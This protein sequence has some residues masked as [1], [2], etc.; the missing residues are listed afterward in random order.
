M[1]RRPTMRRAFVAALASA[2]LLAPA[3]LAVAQRG[4]DRPPP[5]LRLR[6]ARGDL[7]GQAAHQV[8]R[9][10][11]EQPR[12]T[13]AG[14]PSGALRVQ[15]QPKRVQLGRL[16]RALPA[17]HPVLAWACR[18]M[19]TGRPLGV[20]R[21]SERHRLDPDGPCVRLL[22]RLE[23]VRLSPSR[24]GRGRDRTIPAPAQRPVPLRPNRPSATL[25]ALPF[26]RA[27][28]PD[29]RDLPARRGERRPDPGPGRHLDATLVR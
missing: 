28:R 9:C 12:N 2:S 15:P 1:I 18:P 17:C 6:L 23:G 13:E 19:G 11:L 16:R 5:C 20:Q 29:R 4:A 27:R 25:L 14:D 22:G 21:T 3:Q 7:A 8:R 26:E 24:G 10:S